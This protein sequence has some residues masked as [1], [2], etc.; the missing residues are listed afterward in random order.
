MYYAWPISGCQMLIMNDINSLIVVTRFCELVIFYSSMILFRRTLFGLL[1][2]CNKYISVLFAHLSVLWSI[3]QL[4][5]LSLSTRCSHH[6]HLNLFL[7]YRRPSLIS[8][9]YSS[10][11]YEVEV[12]NYTLVI[13]IRSL[14]CHSP[15]MLCNKI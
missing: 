10:R 8:P 6:L 9:L 5:Y 11:L 3:C 1:T 4:L 2:D 15:R 14:L 13:L 7:L 12:D